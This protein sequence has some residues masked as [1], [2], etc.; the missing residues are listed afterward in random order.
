[1]AGYFEDHAGRP[2]AATLA[3]ALVD[4]VAG[5]I[6]AL[7]ARHAPALV[8]P[9][10]FAGHP[11]GPDTRSDLAYTAGLLLEAGRKE[12]AGVPLERAILSTLCAL[13]GAATHT[14]YSYRAAES[15]A[16]I[17]GYR[18]NPL[19]AE[20]GPEA[21]A[22]LRRAFDS[23][24]SAE[25]IRAG[26]LPRNY[27]VVVA[28][29]EH[30]RDQLGLLEDPAILDELLARCRA[31][32][33][34]TEAGWIDD[35]NEQR[36]QH[37]IYT[38]DVFLFAEPL[39]ERIGEPWTAGLRRVLADV[40]AL[41]LSGGAI[42]WGRSIGALGLAMSVELAA[43][44]SSRGLVANPADW[45]A[46]GA[47]AFDELRR[48]YTDG[49]IRA[50]QHRSTMFYRGP[51]RRLQMSLD[52][53]GKLVAAALEL[54][55]APALRAGAPVDAFRPV[56]RFVGM[57]APGR[58]AHEGA[59][60][61]RSRR[62]SFVLPLVDGYSSDY[63]PGPR[64][65]GTFEVPTSGP[66]SFVPVVH[67]RGQPLVAAG[68]PVCVEHTGDGMLEVE[69][70][71][72]RKVGAGP[73][74]P[75]KIEGGRTARYRVD[76]RRLV[77]E[78]ALVLD[79]DPDALDALSLQVPE[80]ARRPLRVDFEADVPL[81]VDRIDVGGLAEYR[82]FWSELPVV[83]QA[84]LAPAR[85]VSLR[86]QVTPHL[87]VSSSADDAQ[88]NEALYAPLADRV[89]TR[90]APG[91]L[92]QRPRE[93][94]RLDVLHVH[95]PEWWQGLDLE[96][97]RRA[98]ARLDEAG[99]RILWT[100]HNLVPHRTRGAEVEAL[101]QLWAEHA[102][103]VI[104]HTAWGQ[105]R[106]LAAYR[107]RDDCIH[108]IHPHGHWGPQLD[109]LPHIDRAEAEAE[110]GLSPCAMR[111]GV[112][113]APRIEKDVQLVLDGFH[114]CANPDLQLLVVCLEG[115]EVPD[116]PRIRALP[117]RH[118]NAYVYQRRLAVL[119]AVVFPFREG[120]LMTGTAFD[121][122]GAG[123][124]AIVS[125]WPVLGEVFG[126]A[127][128]A[129]GSTRDDL[130]DC[131]EALTPERLAASARAVTALRAE[132]EWADIAERH[133]ALLEELVERR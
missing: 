45:L 49:V 92:P 78:E 50:H 76:G 87:R 115:E 51:A 56:D 93:L 105:E 27:A 73:E 116:D 131:L 29:C 18:D 72:W 98:L 52:V 12:L 19:L 64:A 96:R 90:Q 95:W 74:E 94:A 89:V 2:T 15:L 57:G 46:R 14:F 35:S 81:R 54:R 101:Y 103:A 22:N 124:A 123:K 59:W 129:Y 25:A 91:D 44:G 132:T 97:H 41:A 68:A 84:D 75:A 120:M 1:M 107:Y 83:H 4:F 71:G 21:L 67:R 63:L 85:R 53:L 70:R 82:S 77:V 86:W 36:G 126:E 117:A 106:A 61:F 119:D 109:S 127:A 58:N 26:Q 100:Q 80:V 114:A 17:G 3:D 62:L 47:W 55:R 39:A 99:T 121:A 110:L 11:V 102:H 112:I 69:Y 28:R 37:D 108:R 7:A 16:R 113:G 34:Q 60:G 24:A 10:V 40:D 42:V 9:R 43:L 79:T 125:D 5:Q 88:Y 133:Y 48:W 104:H 32:I 20:L 30:A 130:R 31:L 6:E 66:I 13:D 118:E 38:A 122:I 8:L 33:T 111:L 128:I 65:P 23:S